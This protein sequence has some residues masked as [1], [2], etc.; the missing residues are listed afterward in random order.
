MYNNTIQPP[1]AAHRLMFDNNKIA[2]NSIRLP[3]IHSWIHDHVLIRLTFLYTLSSSSS[4]LFLSITYTPQ[5]SNLKCDCKYVQR[6]AIECI[7]TIGIIIII[8]FTIH[9]IHRYVDTVKY[10]FIVEN[11]SEGIVG[12]SIQST[13]RRQKD[14]REPENRRIGSGVEDMGES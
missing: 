14:E 6:A 3:N 13:R 9:N 5:C 4:F 8:I 1:P 7:T 12:R 10:Y 11:E 2:I